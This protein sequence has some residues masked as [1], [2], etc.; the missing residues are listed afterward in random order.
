MSELIA[1]VK[2]PKE[3]L[4]IVEKTNEPMS[5][6]EIVAKFDP[7]FPFK[8][9]KVANGFEGHVFTITG[10]VKREKGSITKHP[11]CDTEWVE[12]YGGAAYESTECTH[13]LN[14][15]ESRID[16]YRHKKSWVLV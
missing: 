6:D 12:K 11:N 3:I 7:G 2:L 1:K 9:R 13:C 4:D 14:L 10:L 16:W 5:L 15:D 8:A